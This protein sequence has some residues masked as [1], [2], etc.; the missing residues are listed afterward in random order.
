MKFKSRLLDDDEVR[1]ALTRI[2]HEVVEKNKGTEGLCFVGIH[3][4]GISLAKRLVDLVEKFE[5]KQAP[6]GILDITLYRD[7]LSEIGLQPR[8]RETRIPFDLNGKAV[9]LVDDVLY[10]GRTARAAL[11]ALIDLGRPSR[12]YLAVLVDRGHRELPIRADFVGKNLPTSKSEV[13]KVKTLEDD[14]EDAVELWE[15]EVA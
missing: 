10:T 1:R 14:G 4:R 9:V 13:V 6:M 8:V 3:T 5:G 11:D 12:I 7:D 15:L 2:A